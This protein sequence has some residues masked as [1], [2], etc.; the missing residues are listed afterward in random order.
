MQYSMP[1]Y[2]PRASITHSPAL[3]RR[4]QNDFFLVPV[5]DESP[6]WLDCHGLETFRDHFSNRSQS[7]IAIPQ[8]QDESHFEQLGDHI[9]AMMSVTSLPGTLDSDIFSDVIGLPKE[10]DWSRWHNGPAGASADLDT[11]SPKQSFAA[12]NHGTPSWGI[13]LNSWM[14]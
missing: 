14:D 13:T 11:A 4:D 9:P 8:T 1:A 12:Y 2:Q 7:H 10:D 3:Q 5:Q 6:A